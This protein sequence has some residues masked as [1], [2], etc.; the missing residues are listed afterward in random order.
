MIKV[1]KSGRSSLLGGLI[2]LPLIVFVGLP[3]VSVI[4]VFAVLFIL[5]GGKSA[6]NFQNLGKFQRKEEN[7]LPKLENENIG[8]YSIKR[9]EKDPSVIEVL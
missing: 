9:D 7:N 5:L 6:V 3:L 2:A 8:S 4:G 1:Y